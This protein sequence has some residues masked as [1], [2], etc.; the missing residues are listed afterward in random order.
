MGKSISRGEGLSAS[1]SAMELL[2]LTLGKKMLVERGRS[3]LHKNEP[4]DGQAGFKILGVE[5]YDNKA[6]TIR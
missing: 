6:A 3:G 2:C 5:Y 4:S 1:R